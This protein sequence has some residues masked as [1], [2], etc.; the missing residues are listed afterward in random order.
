MKW[1]KCIILIK[2]YNIYNCTFFSTWAKKALLSSPGEDLHLMN[3]MKNE[4]RLVS[5]NT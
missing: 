3:E 1:D 5:L 4:M 2:I